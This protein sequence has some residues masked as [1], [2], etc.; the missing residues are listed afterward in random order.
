MKKNLSLFV[1][2]LVVFG[3]VL[4]LESSAHVGTPAYYKGSSAVSSVTCGDAY[5][6]NVSN[7]S[8][9]SIW[10]E[11]TKNGTRVFVGPFYVPMASY[12]SVCKENDPKSLGD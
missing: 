7:H 5:T 8:G 2:I 10:L 3:L 6:F 11:Q 4:T 1:G 9:T 12:T